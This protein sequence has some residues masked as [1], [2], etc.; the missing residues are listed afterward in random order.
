VA[1]TAEYLRFLEDLFSVVS[2]VSI[3]RMFGGVGVFRNGLMFALATS[4]GRLAMKTDQEN[5]PAFQAEGAQEWMYESKGRRTMK[6]GY[7]YVPERLL[8][9]S[10]EFR[11]W[12]L[13]AYEA[14]VRADAKKPP[15]QRKHNR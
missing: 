14:A 1:L 2:G 6:M 3:R 12:A 4:E 8:E 13:A 5:T 15:R 9:E 11:S 10:D 7:W